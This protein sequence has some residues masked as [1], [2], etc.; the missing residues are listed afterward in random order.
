M[1]EKQL[2]DDYS[3]MVEKQLADARAPLNFIMRSS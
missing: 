2:E 1:V 3:K